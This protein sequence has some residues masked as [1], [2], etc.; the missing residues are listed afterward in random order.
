M[1]FLLRNSYGSV[2]IFTMEKYLSLFIMHLC[3]TYEFC[4]VG[5][6]KIQRSPTIQFESIQPVYNTPKNKA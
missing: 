6:L 4:T 1:N 5:S 2:E 3:V